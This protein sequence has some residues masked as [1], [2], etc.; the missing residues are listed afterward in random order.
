M[1]VFDITKSMDL[2]RAMAVCFNNTRDFMMTAF[3]ITEDMAVTAMSVGV[4]FGITQVVDANVG[5]HAIIPKW[6]F[7]PSE[8]KDSPSY[9]P[10]I[11][12][13]TSKPATVK[14]L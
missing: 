5:I 12:P 8:W 6:M 14:L 3:D 7:T 10:K 13:G 9:L 4:D 11:I 2:N 1:D